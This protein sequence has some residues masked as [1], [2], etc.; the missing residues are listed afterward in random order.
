MQLQMTQHGLLIGIVVAVASVVV[1]QALADDSGAH[2][3]AERFAGA[4]VEKAPL[5]KSKGAISAEQ[6]EDVFEARKGH[7]DLERTDQILQSIEARTKTIEDLLEKSAQN[8]LSTPST[9]TNTQN[10][11]SFDD[12]ASSQS[13]DASDKNAVTDV[14]S[15]IASPMHE[16]ATDKGRPSIATPEITKSAPEGASAPVAAA[17]ELL[18]PSEPQAP[19]D[20]TANV[21]EL[22]EPGYALGGPANVVRGISEASSLMRSATVLLVLQ[23]GDKGIRRFKKTADPVLCG[24]RHCYMSHGV[25]KKAQRMHRGATLGPFNTLGRRAGA[26]RQ[27]LACAF[28]HVDV[29]DNGVLLQPVDLK[30]MRHDRRAYR[31]VTPDPTCTVSAGRLFCGKPIVAKTWTAWVVPEHIAQ[32][33]GSDALETAL[34]EGLPNKPVPTIHVKKAK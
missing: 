33:A 8:S 23:P 24:R 7:T 14:Q 34:Q 5:A 18:T 1:T 30:F 28:R 17:A 21:T 27:T 12:K 25:K 13:E 22:P 6:V 31:N 29:M 11:L 19:L 3:L 20:A 32:E 2:S 16:I 15:A 4:H 9:E 10:I 26:C